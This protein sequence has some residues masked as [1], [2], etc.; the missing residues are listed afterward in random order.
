M[1]EVTQ[2]DGEVDALDVLASIPIF[3]GL[4]NEDAPVRVLSTYDATTFD[5]VG[6][7]PMPDNTAA[8][9]FFDDGSRTAGVSVTIGFNLIGGDNPDFDLVASTVTH[10][11][12]YR[13]TG[14]FEVSGAATI[15]NASATVASDAPRSV[16]W[17][18]KTDSKAPMNTK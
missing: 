9:L 4:P 17:R 11:T 13:T 2:P 7:V 10:W 16:S 3:S 12:Y 14:T 5:L 8:F 1:S 6:R 15:D 18:T